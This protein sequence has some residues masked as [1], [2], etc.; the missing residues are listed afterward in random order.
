MNKIASL[1]LEKNSLASL[2]RFPKVIFPEI[3]HFISDADFTAKVHKVIFNAA[4]SLINNNEEVNTLILSEKINNLNIYFEEVENI[5]DYLEALSFIHIN[6]KQ[7]V[8]SFK[9]LKKVTVRREIFETAR[10]LAKEMS[11]C[12]NKSFEEIISL[13]DNLYNE[14]MSI[15]DT[16]QDVE[17]IYEGA[18]SLVES[19]DPDEVDQYLYGPHQRLNELYGSLLRPGNITVLCARAGSHKTTWMCDYAEK[20]SEL[21]NYIPI[22]HLD[23]GEM[24]KEE[25]LFRRIA[26]RSGVPYYY[27]ESGKYKK[28][29]ELYEKVSSVWEDVK[30]IPFYYYNVGGYNVNQLKSLIKR[31]YLSKVGRFHHNESKPFILCY[32]YIKLS[33]DQDKNRKE[34]QL[35][36]DIMADLK[37]FLTK[38]VHVGLMTALQANR[39]GIVTNK[40]KDQVQDDEGVA[41]MSDRVIQNASHFFILRKK[42]NDQLLEE[43]NQYGNLILKALKTRHLGEHRDDVLNPVVMPDG[44]FQNNYLNFNAR[45]F[46]IEEVGD[47]RYVNENLNQV[48]ISQDQDDQESETFLE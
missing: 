22:L 8:Q 41:S 15:Y 46:S 24:S 2:I 20:T 38:E 34:Y 28:N 18:E 44:T 42:T 29:K 36:G 7:G 37:T 17:N 1:D 10:N 5:Y 16:F 35:A 27:I 48:D 21:N 3:F 45:N 13:A 4:E 43:N 47:L 25:I 26:S 32:D 11:V 39:F 19:I 14:R 23:N 12:G 30:K 9:E 6:E 33:G 40:S 31:F